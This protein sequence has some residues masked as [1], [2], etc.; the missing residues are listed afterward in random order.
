M[1]GA[2]RF[3][4]RFGK[5]VAA[6]LGVREQ[7]AT[8]DTGERAPAAASPDD[9]RMRLRD[10]GLL[11]VSRI[12]PD[13]SQP[14][15]EFDAEDLGRLA[16][17]IKARGILAPLRVRWDAE[18]GRWVLIAG[19]RRLRAAALAGL[20]HVP[21][22]C[23]ERPLTPAEILIDQLTEN[24]LREDLKPVEEARAFRT[25]ME[26]HG[27][28][29][30]GLAES[31]NVSPGKVSKALAL[32]DLPAGIQEQVDA[33]TIPAS[34]GYQL[35]KVD[36]PAEQQR[37][38]AEITTGGAT[39]EDVAEAARQKTPAGRGRPASKTTRTFKVKGGAV[40]VTLDRKADHAAVVK[41]LRAALDQ[42]EQQQGRK[43]A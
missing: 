4:E 32:L 43:A 38:A 29:V 1:G 36:D 22:V 5:N 12:V 18:G 31:L 3:R 6:S 19:E 2:D 14:R 40:V 20:E 15:Q 30:R 9:G 21:V 39:R 7:Q 33:G 10:A 35:A 25:L 26:S 23:V 37:L 28:T 8:V 24:L 11:E 27:L 13:P 16:A 34:A 41:A 17:S 42:A